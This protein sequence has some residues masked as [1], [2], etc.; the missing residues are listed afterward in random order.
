[1][2]GGNVKDRVRAALKAAKKRDPDMTQTTV[3]AAIGMAQ[4]SLNRRLRGS[5]PWKAEELRV[6]ADHIGVDVATLLPPTTQGEPLPPEGLSATVP[7][8]TQSEGDVSATGEG[9]AASGEHYVKE[10]LFGIYQRL[11]PERRISW[12]QDGLNAAHMPGKS[13]AGG[14]Q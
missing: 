7:A 1:M 9:E 2:Q 4:S 10:L 12:V 5:I 6:F 3:A 11:T 13:T 8:S 14:E